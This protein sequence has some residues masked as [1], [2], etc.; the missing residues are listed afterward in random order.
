MQSI[1]CS[2]S[3]KDISESNEWLV[4]RM[5]MQPKKDGDEFLFDNYNLT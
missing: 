2:V 3:L 5:R 4:K 1:I